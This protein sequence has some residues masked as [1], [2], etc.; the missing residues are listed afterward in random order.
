MNPLPTLTNERLP[1]PG[2]YAALR[3]FVAVARAMSFAGAARTL[4]LSSSALSQAVRSLED[5]LGQPLLHRTT[6]SMALTDAGRTLFDHMEPLVA[7]MADG[8]DLAKA[9]GPDLRGTL[10]IH[11]ARLAARL[12]VAP[13][14]SRLAARH[15]DLV[16]ELTLD[17]A[18][19]DPVSDGYDA[20]IRLG[21]VIARDMVT[22]SLG[23]PLRQCVVASPAYRDANG[24]PSTPA[25]LLDHR[26]IL[27]RWPGQQT[28]YGWEFE[29]DGRWFT[30]RP[31]GALVV[32]DREFA[33][34]AAINGDGIAM[35]AEPHVS[36]HLDAGRLVSMLE[37]WCGTHPGFHLCYPQRRTVSRELRAFVDALF[38]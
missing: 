32:N 37:R 33:M 15:P 2:E 7:A 25:G 4:G 35:L 8:L 14:L 21:E 6:R 19:V 10:R 1:S 9:T 17:D 29:E 31:A 26:C 20:A 13:A 23:P 18:I 28:P 3:A 11:A 30:V 38:G 16:V 22:R 5:R 36:H 24:L 12:H 34:L 27:W